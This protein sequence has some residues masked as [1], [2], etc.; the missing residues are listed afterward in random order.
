[1]YKYMTSLDPKYDIDNTIIHMADM[2]M[3]IHVHVHQRRSWLSSAAV[4]LVEKS[5]S[6]IL[7]SMLAAGIGAG[8]G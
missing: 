5:E 1:M 7:I 4:A 6:Q 8:F 3:H 2:H